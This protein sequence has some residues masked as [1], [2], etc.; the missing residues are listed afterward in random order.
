VARLNH[1]PRKSPS[2]RH[3]SIA[4]RQHKLMDLVGQR[5]DRLAIDRQVARLKVA[6][7]IGVVA[8]IGLIG[9]DAMQVLMG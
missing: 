4:T 7:G 8:T 5:A 2:F 1:I 3:G 6:I 9:F